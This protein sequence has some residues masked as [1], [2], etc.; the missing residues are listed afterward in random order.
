MVAAP[1]W[2]QPD[3]AVLPQDPT[4][5]DVKTADTT[6]P[7]RHRLAEIA[8]G[9]R[10]PKAGADAATVTQIAPEEIA[11]Q[12]PG[13]AKDLA[14]LIPGA[15]VPV[16]SRGE[17]LIHLRA[18]GE[19]QVLVLLDGAQLMIPWDYF[20]DWSL[21]PASLVGGMTVTK[22]ASSLIWG[23]NVLG[24]AVNLL[25]KTRDTAGVSTQLD[26]FGGTQQ[27]LGGNLTHIGKA[28]ALD[29]AAAAGW[30]QHGDVALPH[31]AKSDPRAAP[32]NNPSD[33]TRDNSD[34]RIFNAMA[35][36]QYTLADEA[37]VSLTL[38]HVD[39]DKS[40][41]TESHRNPADTAKNG[42]LRYWRYPNWRN[43][44]VIAA[45][46]Q[47]YGA[48]GR[49]TLK[50]TAWVQQFGQHIDSYTDVTQGTLKA[51]QTD[52]DRTAGARV[53]LDHRLGPGALRLIGNVLHSTHEQTDRTIPAGDVA[54]ATI[55]KDF[56]QHYQQVVA[57]V[58][59]EYAWQPSE[60]IEIRGGGGY[61][62]AAMGEIGPF[63]GTPP[64]FSAPSLAAGGTWAMTP[65][66]LLRGAAGLKARFPTQRELYGGALGKFEP[67]PDL[68]PETAMLG[69]LGVQ[70]HNKDVQVDGTVFVSDV[71]DTIDKRKVTVKDSAT[72]K[73]VSKDQRFNLP[74][75]RALGFEA[76][77]RWR[78]WRALACN[79]HLTW[80]HLRAADA[81]TGNY[82]EFLTRRP[83]TIGT[84]G[85]GWMPD[86]G[87]RAFL[88][89]V[90]TGT[91]HSFAEVLNSATGKRTDVKTE[92]PGAALLNARVGWKTTFGAGVARKSLELWARGDNLLDALFLPTDGLPEPGRSFQG[93]VSAEF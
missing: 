19:R 62:M 75:S 13:S 8:V 60:D 49:N 61:D 82:S 30:L 37:R 34:A 69:D 51:D 70:F 88:Q 90:H 74:G 68:Q 44:M 63:P 65:H 87:P 11:L 31:G 85:L 21:V 50:A 9:A 18:A 22:G 64:T 73:D 52:D 14:P 78:P 35:R 67:N 25:T 76:A 6:S 43:S 57:S 5:A 16:N 24:G 39:A 40:V 79:G 91:S 47:P 38:M 10:S 45:Y 77:W 33:S 46:E 23:T 20:L 17:A 28:G 81:T 36:A 2:S 32:Y 58:G 53:V 41:P 54:K 55:N 83:Q 42:S 4:A 15:H 80:M 89:A 92:L 1:A 26:A 12:P 86:T 29:W 7:R 84:V 66:L 72:G 3:D 71:R 27:N 56:P 48:G 59:G 93:G